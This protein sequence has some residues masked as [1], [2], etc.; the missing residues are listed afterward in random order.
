MYLSLSVD[1][2]II[3]GNRKIRK[4]IGTNATKESQNRREQ[5]DLQ[6]N[7]RKKTSY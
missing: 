2:K 4:I 5:L 7:S 6:I 3:D 1:A